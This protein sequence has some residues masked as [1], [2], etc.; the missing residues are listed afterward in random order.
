MS[1]T[2]QLN[3][4]Q[5][6]SQAQAITAAIRHLLASSDNAPVQ[7][8]A[9][10]IDDTV[11]LDLPVRIAFAGEYSAGKSTVIRALTG[12]ASIPI[13]TEITTADASDWSWHGITITDTPGILT[14]VRPEHDAITTAAILKSDL[15]VYVT[16]N[17]LLNEASAAYFRT[18]AIEHRKAA[19]TML[20]VNKMDRHALGNSAES[21]HI[22]LQALEPFTEPHTPETVR[23]ICIAAQSYLTA[24]APATPDELRQ[25]YLDESNIEQLIAS[26]DQFFQEQGTAAQMARPI[27][28]AVTA[29][30]RA[31]ALIPSGNADADAAIALQYRILDIANRTHDQARSQYQRAVAQFI[32]DLE[33]EGHD[34][35]NNRFSLDEPV[36]QE[37]IDDANQQSA[38]LVQRHS[39]NL[40]QQF[41]H[42]LPNAAQSMASEIANLSQQP[43][44]QHIKSQAELNPG[45]STTIGVISQ[46]QELL[47]PL[48]I[49]TK[50]YATAGIAA[51]SGSAAHRAILTMG[52][53]AGAK[54]AP[55][56]AVRLA[57]RASSALAILGVVLIVADIALTVHQERREA[58]RIKELN[59]LRRN[60]ANNFTNVAQ[61]IADEA[62]QAA[63]AYLETNTL[64]VRREVD[65]S[66]RT[67][68]RDRSRSNALVGQLQDARDRALSLIDEMHT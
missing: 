49:G 59:K 21:N 39:D 15:L 13:G 28:Q 36:T 1:A 40:N 27:H 18:L 46:F 56:Q 19:E 43:I 38:S 55:W 10:H 63:E 29:A 17:E 62:R 35:V 33:T 30:E 57:S 6:H 12:D 52:R 68:N 9:D 41:Q 22:V 61:E 45:W 54:F 14:G 23:A 67:I 44:Y 7:D 16:T 24:T 11:N 50:A 32:K 8:L 25:E 2:P 60:F 42:L 34:F 5:L 37:T 65:D 58:K 53:F 4:H 48:T 31:L 64:Q 47:Q 20:V 26:I 3:L 66:I 51:A